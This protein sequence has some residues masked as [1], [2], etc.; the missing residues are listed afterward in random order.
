MSLFDWNFPYPSQRM[1]VLARQAVAT[2]QPLAAQA[3][4]QMLLR[5]G[6]AADAAI[7]TAAALTVL[8]PT[9]NGIGSDAFALVWWNGKVHGLN[10]SGR[11]PKALTLEAVAGRWPGGIED[12]TRPPLGWDFVTV[13]GCV[14]GWRA[15][16]QKFGRLPF[17]DLFEPAIAFARDG[18]LVAPQT[19]G[20]WSRAGTRFAAFDE[21]KRVFLPNGRGPRPGE[22]VTL[23]D[24]ARTLEEIARTGGDSFYRGAL[25]ARILAAAKADG[26]MLREEDLATHRADW[27]DPISID[28]RGLTL[29][30]IPPNGQGIAALSALGMLSHSD[31]AAMQADCPDCIHTQI[32]AMKLAFADAHAF[33]ADSK[34]MTTTS[35]AL[36]DPAYL[37]ERAATIDPQVAADPGHGQPRR[38]GTVLLT[39]A[40]RD[41]MMISFIQSNYMGFGSGVVVP[42]TGIS[43]HN[44]G[45]CFSF[46]PGHPNAFG[47]GKRPYHTIIPAFVTRAGAPLM[48]YG[49]MG[50]FMQPQGHLQVLTRLADF[51]QNPQAAI[52]A[53]RWQVMSGKKVSIEPGFDPE[54]IEE[55]RRRGHDLTLAETRNVSF[56]GAQAI[57]ALEDGYF[58]AS[59]P[60]RDGMAVGW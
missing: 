2:S 23:P 19:A 32:E 40:D 36:L 18:F 30:E 54:L 38:G 58:A 50:G 6:T 35:E 7:A 47:G 48:A 22:K 17:A 28:Y 55:L 11:A 25:A 24:H 4:L 49:V 51:K 60:R 27:V 5:G 39:A 12:P 3:G 59:D 41:G 13:P 33:V 21:F 15:L 14:S 53:P 16:S 34:T 9:S 52:D 57:L 56:G 42:E 26:A 8:E 45:A 10:A 43:L 44:R 29:H 37:Q 46:T 20:G 1:P 31:F